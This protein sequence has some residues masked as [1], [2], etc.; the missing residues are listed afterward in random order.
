LADAVRAFPTGDERLGVKYIMTVISFVMMAM[1]YLPS[2][3]SYNLHRPP[4]TSEGLQ[5]EPPLASPYTERRITVNNHKKDTSAD[6]RRESDIPVV[7]LSS[8]WNADDEDLTDY[9]GDCDNLRQDISASREP[10]DDATLLTGADSKEP[11][12]DLPSGT[13]ESVS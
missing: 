1:L 6:C 5:I 2:T 10:Y 13:L 11:L 8:S 9:T 12:V 4:Y 7:L 3:Q